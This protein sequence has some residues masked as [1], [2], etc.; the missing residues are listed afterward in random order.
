MPNSFISRFDHLQPRLG[1]HRQSCLIIFLSLITHYCHDI[2]K[3]G[4]LP[5]FLFQSEHAQHGA[6]VLNALDRYELPINAV[7]IDVEDNFVDQMKIRDCIPA[8]LSKR[9]RT[10]AAQ[11]GLLSI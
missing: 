6:T 1:E 10:K 9:P 8:A 3:V 5:T 11:K 7:T 2:I 4:N